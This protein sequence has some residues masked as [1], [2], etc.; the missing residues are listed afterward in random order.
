MAQTVG[1]SRDTPTTWRGG[2]GVS[3]ICRFWVSLLFWLLFFPVGTSYHRG[4]TVAGN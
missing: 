1:L 3:I 2:H 4:H